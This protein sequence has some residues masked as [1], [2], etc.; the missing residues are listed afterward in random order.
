VRFTLFIN[1]GGYLTENIEDQKQYFS[2]SPP[3]PRQ[4]RGGNSE[5]V[6]IPRY[7]LPKKQKK[8]KDTILS[9]EITLIL[10]TAGQKILAI[11]RGRLILFCGISK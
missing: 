2:N 1:G 6:H 11:L 9:E 7:P 10:P 8:Y 4:P 3:P 5:I